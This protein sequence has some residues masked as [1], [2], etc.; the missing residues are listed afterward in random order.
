MTKRIYLETFNECARLLC[1]PL[2]SPTIKSSLS[3][4]EYTGC[5]KKSKSKGIANLLSNVFLSHFPELSMLV[6]YRLIFFDLNVFLNHRL[7]AYLGVA[8]LHVFFHSGKGPCKYRK[9]LSC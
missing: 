9:Y 2:L 3:L 6:L 7:I 5:L 8:S 4:Y 1:F